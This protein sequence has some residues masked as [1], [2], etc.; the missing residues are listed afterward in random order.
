M[1]KDEFYEKEIINYYS[2]IETIV[3]NSNSFGYTDI[4]I[5]LE[6]LVVKL[7]KILNLGDFTN[8]N[9]INISFPTID[10]FDENSKIGI[11]VTSECSSKKIESTILGKS[12]Y[13]IKFFFLNSKY[14]PRKNTINKYKN[15]NE[16]DILNFK[17]CL[18]I[19]KSSD[20]LQQLYD[21]FKDNIVLPVDIELLPIKD[22]YDIYEHSIFLNKMKEICNRFVPTSITSK[23]LSHLENNNLLILTGNPGVGKT[24]NSYFLTA[25][26]IESGYTLL[27]SPNNSLKDILKKYNKDKKFVLF[28]DDVFGS[29][30]KSF[31]INLGEEEIVS[32]LESKS[33]NLKIIINS[34]SSIFED[35]N[36][37]FD[38][39]ERLKLK[40]FVIEVSDFTCLEKARILVKHLECNSISNEKI[41]QLFE[42]DKYL[43]DNYPAAQKIYKILFHKNYNPRAIDLAT[44]NIDVEINDFVN[45]VLNVLNNPFLIYEH[46]YNNNLDENNRE[47]LRIIY[48]K[49]RSSFDSTIFVDDIFKF[50][51]KLNMSVDVVRLSLRKLEKSFICQYCNQNGDYI[52]KLYNPS[53]LDFCSIMF[54]SSYDMVKYIDLI[55][56]PNDLKNVIKNKKID[57]AK[58]IEKIQE[59]KYCEYDD[60][61]N[62]SPERIKASGDFVNYI[63]DDI[64]ENQK[65]YYSNMD[66]FCS[67]EF[68]DD[69]IIIS[70]IENS[71]NIYKYISFSKGNPRYIISKRILK[72]INSF[73]NEK[74]KEILTDIASELYSEIVFSVEDYIYQTVDIDECQESVLEKQYNQIETDVCEEFKNYIESNHINITSQELIDVFNFIEKYSFHDYE[75]SIKTHFKKNNDKRNLTNDEIETIAYL[76]EYS[77]AL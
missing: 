29:N 5:S 44:T 33:D 69:S 71:I 1:L 4:N 75:E 62:I 67:D 49:S 8:C 6:S 50:A 13:H 43:F 3:K 7:L 10:L 39:I 26:L 20:K 12:D 31:M 66:Y 37:Q 54:E 11:Q 35:V 25:K 38:K 23:C 42:E 52:C 41:K 9:N 24:Y 72:L 46:A 57:D 60:L 47:I 15:F 34:R 32:L 63:I 48:L 51:V 70:K 56:D 28:I 2:W 45:Y 64:F 55:D 76:K 14:N 27:H 21:F 30:E 58:K 40:P 77:S 68:V 22:G 36:N 16:N 74:R 18:I 53:I 19:A 17:K 59:L 61:K 65:Y 73:S